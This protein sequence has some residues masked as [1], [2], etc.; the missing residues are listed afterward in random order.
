M[1]TR[2][3]N[4]LINANFADRVNLQRNRISVL[5]ERLTTGKRINRPSDDPIGAGVVINLRITQSEINQYN[6]NAQAANQKLVVADNAINGYTDLLERI[7]SLTSQA[8]SDTTLQ[9]TKD[10]LAIEV[11]TLRERI[12]SVANT[13]AGTE[14]VFG[15]TR[16]DAPP[17]DPITGTPAATPT[18]A[19]YVQIEPGANAIPVGVTADNIFAD[20]TSDIFADIDDT[21]AALRGTGDPVADKATLENMM[22]RLNT[23]SDLGII[24]QTRIGSYMAITDLAQEKLSTDSIIIDSQASTIEDTDFAESAIKFTEAQQAL[25]ATLQVIGRNQRNLLDFLG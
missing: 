22:V 23:Y 20:A 8:L 15:G 16:Q 7:R 3:P 1:N 12:L 17:Y 4:S 13:Q 14:Y 25:E 6:R 21:I 19:R 11:E 5:Q 9:E 2:V 10:L 24:A 18:E